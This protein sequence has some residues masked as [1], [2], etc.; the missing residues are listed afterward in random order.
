MKRFILWLTLGMV[1][2]TEIRQA[3]LTGCWME[4]LPPGTPYEQGMVLN[5][6]GTAESVGMATLKY[7]SW[8][9]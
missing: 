4:V 1:A 2:C 6:D 3:D 5:D 7:R 9:K 8:R